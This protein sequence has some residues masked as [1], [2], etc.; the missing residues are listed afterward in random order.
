MDIENWLESGT[1]A[2]WIITFFIFAIMAVTYILR[3]AP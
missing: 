2:L 1:V 3:F